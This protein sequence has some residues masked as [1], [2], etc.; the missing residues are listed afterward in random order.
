MRDPAIR[1]SPGRPDELLRALRDIGDTDLGQLDAS[2]GAWA[3]RPLGRAALAYLLLQ[4][5]SAWVCLLNLEAAGLIAIE[6]RPLHA[7]IRAL[8]VAPDLRRRGCASAMLEEAATRAAE[9]G[10]EW[11]SVS[12]AAGNTPAIQCALANGY[13]RLRPQY[14]AR[15][16]AGLAPGSAHRVLLAPV[17]GREAAEAITD[18]ARMEAEA[19]DVW[20]AG[21]AT[22]ERPKL[23][24]APSGRTFVARADGRPAGCAH[25]ETRGERAQVWLWLVPAL[26]GSD[27]ELAVLRAVLNTLQGA[28]AATEVRL[29]SGDHLRIAVDRYREAGYQLALEPRFLF[30]RAARAE[31]QSGG[32]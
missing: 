5:G 13:R 15:E 25:L 20:A 32:T 22:L 19:G 18:A 21:Y 14:L 1:I 29:G 28:P 31:Q 17:T 11:L 8:A 3:R 7:R 12:I 23:P 9:R 26:W 10:L 27:L 24:N 6:R 2:I 16:V 4:A 30:L